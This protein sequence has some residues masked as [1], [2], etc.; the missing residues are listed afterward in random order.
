ML[1]VLGLPADGEGFGVDFD[2]V[3][4]NEEQ[5]LVAGGSP[6]GHDGWLQV[7]VLRCEVLKWRSGNGR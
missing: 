3:D 1:T 6:L 7:W 5:A 2:L 4:Q